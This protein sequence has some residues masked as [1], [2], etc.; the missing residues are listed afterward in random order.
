[1]DHHS[2]GHGVTAE[3]IDITHVD[4]LDAAAILLPDLDILLV[5]Q[6]IFVMLYFLHQ[7]GVGVGHVL[8]RVEAWLV[9][10]TE[11]LYVWVFLL[12]EGFYVFFV[13]DGHCEGNGVFVEDGDFDDEF[14]L[15]AD[16]EAVEEEG[17]DLLTR[18]QLTRRKDTPKA[19]MAKR[20]LSLPE[21][22]SLMT[23]GDSMTSYPS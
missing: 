21:A 19:K 10:F 12:C 17:D 1:M 6:E 7:N 3:S 14:V 8:A 22:Y 11:L 2:N 15:E 20:Q 18:D 23:L 9:C 16:K 5:V 4:H 13:N